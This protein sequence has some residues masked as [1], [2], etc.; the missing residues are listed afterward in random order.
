MSPPNLFTTLHPRL[1]WARLDVLDVVLLEKLRRRL[2]LPCD[3]RGNLLIPLVLVLAELGEMHLIRSISQ[4][5]RTDTS[6][7]VRKR[8]ILAHTSS[9]KRLHGTVDDRKR[10]VGHKDLSLGNLAQRRLGSAGID[11]DGSVEDNEACS[12]DFDTAASDPLDDHTVLLKLLAERRLLGVV[13]AHQH[14]VERVLGSADAAHGVVDTSWAETALD[15]LETAARAEDD[16]GDGDAHVLE[17]DVRVSV[18]GVVV[19]VHGEHAVDGDALGGGGDED[20]GLLAV[21]VLVC[22]VGLGHDDVYL[23]ARVAGAGRPPFLSRVS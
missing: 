2:S 21:L 22:G 13:D 20:H 14:P 17:G 10:H 8:G 7:R 9:T 3:Q 6:P 18:G 12:V 23:A 4:L 15:D 1:S 19:T 5:Q 16:L 11:L